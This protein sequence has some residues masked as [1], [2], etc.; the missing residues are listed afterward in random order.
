MKYGNIRKSIF[1]AVKAAN[2]TSKSSAE[3]KE[4]VIKA[5]VKKTKLKTPKVRSVIN[6]GLRTPAVMKEVLAK[7]AA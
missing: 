7:K 6:F 2:L 1:T 3:A 4:A 5:C